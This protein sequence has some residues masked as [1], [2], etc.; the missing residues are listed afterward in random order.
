MAPA[1]PVQKALDHAAQ[2]AKRVAEL[3]AAREQQV[4]EDLE[5]PGKPWLG[6]IESMANT[7]Q[8]HFNSYVLVTCLI[9]L[10]C[11]VVY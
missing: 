9:E 4:D 1:D 10:H 7:G 8:R 11:F 2:R 3:D 6:C 5:D